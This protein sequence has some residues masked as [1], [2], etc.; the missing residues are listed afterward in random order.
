[1]K[2]VIHQRL[3]QISV[4]SMLVLACRSAPK[5]DCDQNRREPR[6]PSNFVARLPN[7]PYL[8]DSLGTGS[9]IGTVADSVFG[10]GVPGATVSA[11]NGATRST[12]HY[13]YTD[14][15]GGFLLRDLPP[16]SHILTVARIGYMPAQSKITIEAGKV[17]TVRLRA[18]PA[19]NLEV[20]T[21]IITS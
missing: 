1:V 13:A 8:L 11:G 10:A 4:A 20:C 3:I 5:G 16:G 9:V 19:T 17:D 15:A 7:S 6:A 21:T 18:V 14:S 12:S 2:T